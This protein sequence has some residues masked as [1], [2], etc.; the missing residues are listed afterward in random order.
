[1]QQL[2][3]A[4]DL[5]EH[6]DK[7]GAMSLVLRILDQHPA[8]APAIKLKGLLLEESGHPSEAAA[9]FEQALKLAPSDPDLLLEV[10]T[11]KLA[12]GQNAE[13]LKLLEHCVRL[14]PT[15]GDAEFYLAQAY[16]LNGHDDLALAAYRQTLKLDSDNPAAMQKFGELLCATDDCDAA[17]PWLLKAL[18]ADTTLPR[19]DYDIALTDFKLMDLPG[20]AQYAARALDA[21]PTDVPTLQLLADADTK[22]AQ[23]PDAKQ[24]FERILALKPDNVE[25]LLGLGQCELELKNYSAAV[26]KLQQVVRLAPTRPLTHF[27]LA[28]AYA[29]LGKTA[30]AQHETALH[31]LMMEQLTFGRSLESDEREA[32]IKAPA[33]K[34]LAQHR[35]DAA[36]QLYRDRFK[37]TPATPADAYV[38]V[39]K[40]FLLAGDKEDALRNLHRALVLQP[41]VR[42]A[43]T[44]QG[45]VALKAGDLTKA[46]AEFKAELAADP[47]YQ[48]AIAELGEAHYR[49]GQFSDA[50]EQLSKSRTMSPEL[51][52]MLSD[53]YFRTGKISDANLTAETAAAYGRN[54]PELLQQLN[55]LLIRNSQTDLAQRLAANQTQK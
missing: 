49:Q 54:N 28:H 53:S 4:L 52:Y 43:H 55:D 19:I 23:W 48:L 30:D 33:A 22:L 47:S 35:E 25:A 15:D 51:L 38:F 18:H 14:L 27:Y 29:G 9:A 36:L 37:G 7:Q 1:M 31:Q 34:L 13:A 8:F 39:G 11:H 3:Q 44:Y 50:A 12:A 40:L 32:P 5:S 16:H 42:G 6:G 41:T 26:D 17:L 46:E 45:I 24:S 21:Q 2:Q 20:T 10:G